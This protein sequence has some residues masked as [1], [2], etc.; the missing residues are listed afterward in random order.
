[1]PKKRTPKPPSSRFGHHKR[2]PNGLTEEL[3]LS[4]KNRMWYG[5]SV[6]ILAKEIGCPANTIVNIYVG[7]RWANVPWP[8]RTKGG[9]PKARKDLIEQARKIIQT[10]QVPKML[11]AFLKVRERGAH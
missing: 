2:R 10:E 4:L 9:M 7:H 6:G 5:E 3:V 11:R 1:M 8:N